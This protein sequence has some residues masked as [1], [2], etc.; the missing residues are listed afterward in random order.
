VTQPNYAKVLSSY[1]SEQITGE[2]RLFDAVQKAP[3]AVYM[4]M[5]PSK[6]LL[7]YESGL[8]TDLDCTSDLALS[9]KKFHAG[10]VF[11]STHF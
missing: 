10:K 9:E 3:V 8:F 7:N 2:D 5:P 11:E 6:S 4:M 1:K